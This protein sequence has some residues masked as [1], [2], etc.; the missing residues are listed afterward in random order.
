MEK[1][2]KTRTKITDAMRKKVITYFRFHSGNS[3]PLI[4]LNLKMN[5]KT[6]NRILDDY[7]NQKKNSTKKI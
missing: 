5:V 6:V 2:K 1:K 7:L 3:S 4:A